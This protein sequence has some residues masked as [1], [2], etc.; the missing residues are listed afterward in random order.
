MDVSPAVQALW[1]QQRRQITDNIRRYGVHLTYVSDHHDCVTG[2]PCVSCRV[3][4]AEGEREDGIAELFRS[5]GGPMELLPPRLEGPFGYT[6]GM[7]GVGHAELVVLGLDQGTTA[8]VLNGA[9]HR[10][11]GHGEDLMPGQ[12]LQLAG[13]SVLVEEVFTSGMI[14]YEVH[15]Y[16]Q[17]PP[18]EPVEAFQLTWADARGRFPWDAG[19]DP[20]RWPQARPGEYRA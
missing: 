2:P 1:D 6:T 7:F 14:L 15:D 16:Y 11:T 13:R 19:H 18:W 5:M 12:L 8:Q 17:R 4:G 3:H 20:G 10:V 9:A